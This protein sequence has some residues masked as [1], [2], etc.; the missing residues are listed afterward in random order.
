MCRKIEISKQFMDDELVVFLESEAA[1]ITALAN[2]I[3]HGDH[4][5]TEFFRALRQVGYRLGLVS[6][7]LQS[8]NH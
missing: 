2:E 7:C 1:T 5:G 8:T 6:K 4:V 3:E